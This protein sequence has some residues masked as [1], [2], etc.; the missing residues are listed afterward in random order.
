VPLHLAHATMN[1]PVNAGRA[2]ELLSLLDNAIDAGSDISLDTYP[3][4]PGA[5]Y[6][7]ALLPSWAAEGGPAATVARLSDMD[8]RRRILVDIEEIGSDGCHGVPVD[9]ATIEINGV[10]HRR[11]AHLVGHSVATSAARLGV[12]PGELYLD[13]LRDDELGTS[14]LMLVGDEANVRAIMRHHAHTGGSDGLLVGDRPHPR[15]WGTFPRYLGHYV[16]ELG[17]LGLADCVAHLTS[18][19]ARRLGLTDRGVVRVGAA[20]DLVLFDPVTIGDTATFAEPRQAATGVHTVLVDG[21]RTLIDGRP[22]G[23]LP[24]HSIRGKGPHGVRG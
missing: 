24:G 8:T 13:T 16:R 21:V 11:S 1:F 10:R 6:L 4:L 14:C 19:P 15:G 3:Y 22:T 9:W 12:P 2:G 17:V 5:T 23:A 7:A 20:A 18:R